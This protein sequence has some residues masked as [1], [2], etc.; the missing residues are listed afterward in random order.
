MG[1]HVPQSFLFVPRLPSFQ[2]LKFSF[3]LSAL[4]SNLYSLCSENIFSVIIIFSFL[5]FYGPGHT[6]HFG[7]YSVDTGKE[8]L[9]YFSR[10]M[11]H[12]C[13]LDSLGIVEPYILDD[14]P[15]FY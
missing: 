15:S 14:F 3:Y 9:F 13:L 10:E 4:I 7:K 5:L 8:Q 2:A 6:I 1:L 12:K 11:F